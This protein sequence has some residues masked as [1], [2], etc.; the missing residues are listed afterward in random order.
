MTGK[1]VVLAVCL[2][3]AVLLLLWFYFTQMSSI[4]QA[5]PVGGARAG[6]PGGPP[7]PMPGMDQINVVPLPPNPD[8]R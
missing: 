5:K 6:M 3:L 4:L 2:G 7:I 8:D 1:Q